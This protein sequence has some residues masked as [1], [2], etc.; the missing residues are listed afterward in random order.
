MRKKKFI[1]LILSVF[2]VGSTVISS[3]YASEP[4]NAAAGAANEATENTPSP[5][6]NTS[7]HTD[8][9]ED[10]ATSTE[11]NGINP[12]VGGIDTSDNIVTGD[13]DS[14]GHLNIS[15]DAGRNNSAD[16]STDTDSRSSA[17]NSSG[18]NNTS[19]QNIFCK[20]DDIQLS[21]D[22]RLDIS[23]IY[24]GYT[25]MENGIIQNRITSTQV[26][27]GKDTVKKDTAVLTKDSGSGSTKLIA[28]GTG[29]ATVLLINP[30]Q[31][32]ERIRLNVTVVPAK[33]TIMYL[34]GQSNMEGM[35]AENTGYERDKSIENEPGTVYST[36]TPTVLNWAKN[37]TGVDFSSMCTQNNADTFVPASLTS[38]YSISGKL[39][40]YN[41]DALTEDGNG[42]TGPDS[43]IAYEWNQLTGDKVWTVNTAWSGSI[44]S[45]WQPGQSNY[46]R[47]I[48]VSKTAK[49]VYEAEIAAGH[50][51]EGNQ[52]MFWMQGETESADL[53]SSTYYSRFLNMYQKAQSV[54]DTDK[55]GL[56]IPRAAKSNHQ[57]ETDLLMT[58]SRLALYGIGGTTYL[59]N[60]YIVSNM[61]ETW[62]TNSGVA[63][64]FTNKYPYGIDYPT[65]ASVSV[66]NTIADVHNDIHFSQVGHNENGITAADGMYRVL[67]SDTSEVTGFTWRN[68]LG[69]AVTSLRIPSGQSAALTSKIDKQTNSKNIRY[70]V[71]GTGITYNAT[72]GIVSAIHT[73]GVNKIAA[74]VGNEKI[75]EIVVTVTSNDDYSATVGENYTG[76]YKDTKKNKWYYLK[77]SAVDH[78][79]TGFVQNQNGWWYVENGT[80]TFTTTNV[81]SGFINEQ[82]AWWKVVNSKVIFDNDVCNNASGWWKIT[83]GRVDFSFTGFAKN[84]NGWWYLE[85]GKVQFAVN[86][87][88][89][90]TVNNDY[91]WWNVVNGQVVFDTTVANNQNGWWRIVNGK[92]DFSCNSVEKN[93]NGWWYIRGGKVDFSYTGIANNVNGWWRIVNGKVD[94][95]CNSVERNENGWW[96]LSG[97]K[98]DFNYNGIAH[99]SNGWWY[100]RGGKVDFSYNGTVK[101]DGRTY[102]VVGGKVNK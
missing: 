44:I 47:S 94:F 63:S 19:A 37:I 88:I 8:G 6:Y 48:A 12:I 15:N 38:D 76:L 87:V 99:N 90:G 24:P 45:S 83:N 23:E 34:M 52:L 53:E 21:Y 30:S 4:V 71:S 81:V 100:I 31:P 46:E 32:S 33:L 51:T 1:S 97:G 42:K 28:T 102:R 75:S 74:F 56:I 13:I 85:G 77:D 39:L 41:L 9:S 86:N 61:N 92:V 22:D 84:K 78:T 27:N 43:G 57:D 50:Y 79:F 49:G 5:A 101:A 93:A 54:L 17:D 80:I 20:E 72:T 58:G 3:A 25:I 18:N 2:V 69:K 66:P 16:I 64:Y 98:V 73:G 7:L 82:N 14:D 60:V 35:C 68:K 10:G 95:S 96:K 55:C 89:K 67:Y 65:K 26:R 40:S 91:A 59:P 36:Y 11:S 29:T 62:T 70:A